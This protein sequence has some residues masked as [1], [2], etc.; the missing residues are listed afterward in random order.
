MNIV[1]VFPNDKDEYENVE[2]YFDLYGLNNQ[3]IFYKWRDFHKEIT[4]SK[5]EANPCHYVNL[6]KL[7]N[8][9][10]FNGMRPKSNPVRLSSRH[11]NIQLKA[12]RQAL[13]E[14]KIKLKVDEI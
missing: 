2:D 4:F 5:N 3:E 6:H 8:N 10:K 1:K 12:Y 11:F 13:L 9:W 14:F 7:L